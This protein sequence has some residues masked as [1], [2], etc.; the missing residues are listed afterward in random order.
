MTTK[1]PPLSAT[2]KRAVDLL[3]MSETATFTKLF[4]AGVNGPALTALER[5]GTIVSERLE[6]GTRIWRLTPAGLDEWVRENEVT[7]D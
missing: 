1:L 7:E 5:R 6:D 2:Q 3:A 4:E